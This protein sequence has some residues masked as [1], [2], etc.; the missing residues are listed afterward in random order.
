MTWAGKNRSHSGPRGR[1]TGYNRDARF[2][3]IAKTS[4]LPWTFGFNARSAESSGVLE[5]VELQ[6][7][8]LNGL[9]W[10]AELKQDP[11]VQL[12]IVYT[13]VF[14]P[15]TG[16]SEVNAD[17][18][19]ILSSD[20]SRFHKVVQVGRDWILTNRYFLSIDAETGWLYYINV[21]PEVITQSYTGTPLETFLPKLAVYVASKWYQPYTG[22]I[23][24]EAR[25]YWE[26]LNPVIGGYQFVHDFMIPRHDMGAERYF[27]DLPNTS[28]WTYRAIPYGVREPSGLTPSDL[29]NETWPIGRE[30][31]RRCVWRGYPEYKL[32]YGVF[33]VDGKLYI[34]T[35]NFIGEGRLI[36][37]SVEFNPT[38][39]AEVT[40]GIPRST[41][42]DILNMHNFG[43]WRDNYPEDLDWDSICVGKIEDCPVA[44]E[45]TEVSEEDQNRLGPVRVVPTGRYIPLGKVVTWEDNPE[46]K[47]ES[48]N[49]PLKTCMVGE[50]E[51]LRLYISAAEGVNFGVATTDEALKLVYLKPN[52]DEIP[53]PDGSDPSAEVPPPAYKGANGHFMPGGNDITGIIGGHVVSSDDLWAYDTDT[54]P[55]FFQTLATSNRNKPCS[56]ETHRVTLDDGTTILWEGGSSLYQGRNDTQNEIGITDLGHVETEAPPLLTAKEELESITLN[57][58]TFREVASVEG[59]DVYDGG[60]LGARFP[61]CLKQ[62]TANLSGETP[63]FEFGWIN[64]ETGAVTAATITSPYPNDVSAKLAIRYDDATGNVLF[65]VLSRYGSTANQFSQIQIPEYLEGW[66]GPNG[67]QHGVGAL[68][69]SGIYPW[70]NY[71]MTV[72]TEDLQ[73]SAEVTPG[74]ELLETLVPV[75]AYMRSDESYPVGGNYFHSNANNTV[76]LGIGGFSIRVS[77][78]ALNIRVVPTSYNMPQYMALETVMSTTGGRLDFRARSRFVK[79]SF[80]GIGETDMPYPFYSI[81][82][83]CVATY[84]KDRVLSESPAVDAPRY[85]YRRNLHVIKA[86]SGYDDSAFWYRTT[87][88]RW[89]AHRFYVLQCDIDYDKLDMLTAGWKLG[90]DYTPPHG[91]DE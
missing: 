62:D 29:P 12:A 46:G 2:G 77:D 11:P 22:S 73:T 80:L 34:R 9:L 48:L 47:I 18:N 88:R 58:F 49:A 14:D 68:T 61:I 39:E 31:Y 24:T 13:R 64:P 59:T 19:I 60:L 53:E 41:S 91:E 71:K 84:G 38:G 52:G 5:N 27:S 6:V 75:P 16:E 36:P 32:K 17:N 3:S 10:I 56:I 15:A 67:M 26:W 83:V 7:G 66:V 54:A 37:S 33:V 90:I 42:Y 79:N 87:N 89:S 45:T 65:G 44:F 1:K 25:P 51:A 20:E 74:T 70:T 35:D 76:S 43:V 50:E 23:L 63:V 72:G 78:A 57:P 28:S 8:T 30:D 21:H 85:K 40:D 4:L 81:G 55:P 82:T 86:R 69:A